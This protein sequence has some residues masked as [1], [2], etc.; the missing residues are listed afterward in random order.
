MWSTKSDDAVAVAVMD[1]LGTSGTEA[2]Q[3][4][5]GSKPNWASVP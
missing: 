2:R 3:R 1:H 5:D 4:P